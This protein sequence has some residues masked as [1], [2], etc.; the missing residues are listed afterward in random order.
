MPCRPARLQA[1]VRPCEGNTHGANG[2]VR[3]DELGTGT[4]AEPVLPAQSASSP[5]DA[6]PS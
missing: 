4:L 2:R 3:L 1:A 6:G 5:E